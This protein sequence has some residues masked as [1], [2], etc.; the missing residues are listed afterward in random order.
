MVL[1]AAVLGG[2][3]GDSVPPRHGILAYMGSAVAPSGGDDRRTVLE[4]RVRDPWSCQGVFQHDTRR[5]QELDGLWQQDVWKRSGD[6]PSLRRSGPHPRYPP[7]PGDLV[8]ETPPYPEIASPVRPRTNTTDHGSPW[9][10]SSPGGSRSRDVVPR[11]RGQNQVLERMIR[12][13][14]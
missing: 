9:M 1:S 4:L 6:E 8:E 14:E 10:M 11:S 7:Q 12:S 3:L 2:F 5:G 13:S